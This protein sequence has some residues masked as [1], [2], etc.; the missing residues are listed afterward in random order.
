MLLSLGLFAF[1]LE[2][3]PLDQWRR[4]RD[5]R[6]PSNDRVM[7]RP[8]FQYAGP[9]DDDLTLSGRIYPGQL[10]DRKCLQELIE[11]AASGEA[12][13]LVDSEGV[14]HGAF[15]IVGLDEVHRDLRVNAAPTAI[16][17]TLKLKRADEDTSEEPA[18]EGQPGTA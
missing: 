12:W 16:D 18:A 2:S 9:G 3:A 13:P 14:V 1:G 8:A 6:H 5:W 4:T 15:V 10:G 7:A 11:M 17:F